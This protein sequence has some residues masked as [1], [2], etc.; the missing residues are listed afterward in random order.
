MKIKEAAKYCGLTE[1]AMSVAMILTYAG[2]TFLVGFLTGKKM[3][4]MIYFMI[5]KLSSE[6]WSKKYG[7]KW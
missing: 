5:G 7:Y 4:K 1:K 2:S 6:E 3:G